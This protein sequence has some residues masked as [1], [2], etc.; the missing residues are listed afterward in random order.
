MNV[1][2]VL[3][4]S[5]E[6]KTRV[7][8]ATKKIIENIHKKII[9]YARLKKDSCT[10]LVPPLVDDTPLYDRDT[11]IKDIFKTLD[12]EGYV[13]TAF[14]TGQIDIFWNEKLVEEKIKHDAW[15]LD[16]EHRKLKKVSKKNKESFDFLA[17]P[18]KTAPKKPTVDQ[19]IDEQIQKILGEKD[20][21]Q[22]KYK[23]LLR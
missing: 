21:L 9:Y 7:K 23:K 10:Y 1:Q 6:R 17:N 18:Q 20:L 13:V 19:Q 16:H 15:I 5:K 8:A 3:N 12:S 22:N 2:E 11:I 4:I 14:P